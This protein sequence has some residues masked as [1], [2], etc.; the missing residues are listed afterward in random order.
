[1]ATQ[2]WFLTLVARWA[3]TVVCANKHRPREYRYDENLVKAWNGIRKGV[4]LRP[5]ANEKGTGKNV[6]YPYQ[7]PAQ[8]PLGKKPKV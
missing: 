5:G 1:V 7:E 8:V 2:A 6:G 3:Q 4:L